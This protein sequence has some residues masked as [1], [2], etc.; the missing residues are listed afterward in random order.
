ME[1]FRSRSVIRITAPRTK[2]DAIVRDVEDTVKRIRRVEVSLLDL[3]PQSPSSS[4]KNSKRL[5]N[6]PFEDTTL[7][8]VG[9]LTDTD[10]SK[11]SKDKV[12]VV[13][14]IQEKD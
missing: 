2:A 13:A 3:L 1:A 4:G 5:L 14:G 12:R 10:I 6:S 7:H 11:Q 9:R 8:E